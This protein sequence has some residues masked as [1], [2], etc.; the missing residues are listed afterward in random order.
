[1]TL[2][3]E[4]K[5]NYVLVTLNRLATRGTKSHTNIEDLEQECDI[6]EGFK[7]AIDLLRHKGFVES[8]IEELK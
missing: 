3:A 6:G 4:E 5:R 7:P 1:M 2:S 8:S